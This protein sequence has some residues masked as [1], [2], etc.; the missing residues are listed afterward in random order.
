MGRG[1]PTITASSSLSE[2][3]PMSSC[4]RLGWSSGSLGPHFAVLPGRMGQRR[5]R[6]AQRGGRG[7]VCAASARRSRSPRAPEGKAPER[8]LLEPRRVLRSQR[9]SNS[10][11]NPLLRR[12]QE[13]LISQATKARKNQL[14]LF[15]ES[16][17][18]RVQ[19][20]TW[21]GVADCWT[22]G[23]FLQSYGPM[24]SKWCWGVVF[25]S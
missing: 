3:G 13:R 21:I 22:Q 5:G 15:L 20:E 23:S 9:S 2:R 11:L 7:G 25:L 6:G 24:K 19:G 1:V 12:G 16:C 14:F 8:R 10:V 4:S 18:H 17:G